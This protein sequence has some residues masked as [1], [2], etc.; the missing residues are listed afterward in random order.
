MAWVGGWT[1][2]FRGGRRS[3][4]SKSDT[5]KKFRLQVKCK[6]KPYYSGRDIFQYIIGN[7][8]RHLGKIYKNREAARETWSKMKTKFQDFY[9]SVQQ[10]LNKIAVLSSTD[11]FLS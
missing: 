9:Q 7:K 6:R 8:S 3:N 1:E 2:D 11:Q 4:F 10:K 5:R